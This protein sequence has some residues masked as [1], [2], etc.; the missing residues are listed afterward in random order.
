MG[1]VVLRTTF[2]AMR[3]SQGVNNRCATD[4]TFAAA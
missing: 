1:E 2:T 3:R 4:T